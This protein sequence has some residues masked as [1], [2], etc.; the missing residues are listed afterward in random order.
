ME[1]H[2]GRRNREENEEKTTKSNNDE[3]NNSSNHNNNNENNN[4]SNNN[5]SNN[6]II[7]KDEYISE[8]PESDLIFISDNLLYIVQNINNVIFY[9]SNS[10]AGICRFVN[11]DSDDLIKDYDPSDNNAEQDKSILKRF[12]IFQKPLIYLILVFTQP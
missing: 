8:L 10:V 11:K 9:Y 12:I 6:N 7:S 2:S 1:R 4:S 5:C 3:N